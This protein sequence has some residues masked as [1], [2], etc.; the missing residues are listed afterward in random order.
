MAEELFN[1]EPPP[2]GAFSTKDAQAAPIYVNNATVLGY[3][4]E[5]QYFGG[6]IGFKKTV[7]LDIQC[8]VTDITNQSGAAVASKNLMEFLNDSQ[9]YSE[10]ILNGRQMGP[11]K[12]VG[13]SVN[14]ADMVNSA[15]CAVCQ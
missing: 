4:Q 3:S 6:D 7:S 11:A 5:I 10:V 8:V 2:H 9:D 14:S 1:I 12:V 13:F 15:S